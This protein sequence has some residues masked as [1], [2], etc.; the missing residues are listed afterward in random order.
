M[1]YFLTISFPRQHPQCEGQ[2]AS[3]YLFN[4]LAPNRG[5]LL[6]EVRQGKHGFVLQAG[7]AQGIARG[8][9]FDVYATSDMTGSYL[10]QFSAVQ[11]GACR[12]KLKQDTL[13]GV[14]PF[15]RDL[16]AWALQTSLGEYVAAITVAV[17][18][19]NMFLPI[20]IQV[21]KEMKAKRP[22][23][24]NIRLVDEWTPDWEL[25]LNKVSSGEVLFDLNDPICRKSGLQ[26]LPHKISL[27]SDPSDLYFVLASAADFFFLLRH[28]KRGPLSKRVKIEAYRLEEYCP[29][30][31]GS[32]DLHDGAIVRP[33]GYDLNV[34]GVMSAIA[35][36]KSDEPYI[37]PEFY[38]F[39]IVS[40]WEYPLYVWI[41]AFEMNTL[42]ISLS[43]SHRM[44][45][46][47]LTIFL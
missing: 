17:P 20:I 21:V 1:Y 41:F 31:P 19:D 28:S 4:K 42:S 47:Y 12:T 14:I 9:C 25:S 8:A 6:Y 7:E 18:T 5:R 35:Y 24:R 34:A 3:R 30:E 32:V 2:N 13:V 37:D 29:E 39:K 46:F 43:L 44:S 22:G 10:G 38:G 11:L 27:S 23:K 40:T 33:V 26:H 36:D 45:T 15:P 16:I